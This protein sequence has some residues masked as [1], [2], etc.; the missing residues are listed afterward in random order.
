MVAS[1]CGQTLDARNP[2]GVD[3]SLNLLGNGAFRLPKQRTG[4]GGTN[5]AAPAS[6]NLHDKLMRNLAEDRL[7]RPHRPRYLLSPHRPQEAEDKSK[8]HKGFKY[9]A[10][11]PQDFRRR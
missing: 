8:Q 10:A 3:A 4:K 2:F 11:L 1:I 5:F 6:E 7:E 9:M